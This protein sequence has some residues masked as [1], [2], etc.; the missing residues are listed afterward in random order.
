MT[1]YQGKGAAALSVDHPRCESLQ[2]AIRQAVAASARIGRT[3]DGQICRCITFR[4]YMSL[5]LYHPDHGYYRSGTSRIGRDGDFY[6]SAYIGDIMGE[7]LAERLA[8]IASQ[9]FPDGRPVEAMD[10]G[11][12]TGRLGCQMLQT[13]HRLGEA[14]RRFCLTVVED[15]PEHRRQAGELL[16]QE[17]LAGNAR[18]ISSEQAELEDRQ[19]RSCFVVANE[20]LDAFPVHR[21]V[22]E[23]GRLWEWAVHWEE[24]GGALESCLTEPSDARLTEWLD[25]QQVRLAEGQTTEVGLEAAEWTALLAAKL[26]DAVLVLIDYGD[27]TAELTGPH[28]MDGTLLCYEGH[29]VHNDPFRNPG[30]QDLTAHVDFDLI[31]Y[32]ASAAG[33]QEKEYGTQKQFLVNSGIL[34]KLS[35]HDVADPFHPVV[36]RNRAIRQLLLSDGMS[37]LFKVHIWVK[38]NF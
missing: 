32:F 11:G 8:L 33:W 1:E 23:D 5:C 26:G 17:I 30:N 29:R 19:G 35:E 34:T 13:W 14:G 22:Q 12:G 10:W 37:E 3:R 25:R 27:S 21:V 18:V 7:L 6:T 4:D 38:Q 24:A 28:R 20:L 9:L 2:E 36:R 15:N 31:R 16:G